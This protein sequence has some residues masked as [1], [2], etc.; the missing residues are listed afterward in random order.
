MAAQIGRGLAAVEALREAGPVA[1]RRVV[2]AA[3]RGAATE[4]V[5]GLAVSVGRRLGLSDTESTTL[6][7]AAE[8]HDLGLIGV[9]AG[10]LLRPARL[11]REEAGILH[12][13][14]LI[15]ERLLRAVPG[16]RDA[17]RVLRHVHERYDGTGYPDRLAGE[18]IPLASRILHAAITFEAMVSPRPYRD[19]VPVDLARAELRRVAG[20]Q[21]DPDV[22]VALEEVLETAPP[23][24]ARDG[25][26]RKEPFTS[27]SGLPG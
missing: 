15:A 20:A 13:H 8:V 23:E 6:R 22:V 14:P 2:P 1:A 19:P 18:R 24:W 16:L 26:E 5:A 17:A 10:L 9:P 4:H 3:A 11:S 7:R 25:G 21:L 27:A 12:E